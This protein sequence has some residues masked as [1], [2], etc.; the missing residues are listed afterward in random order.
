MVE[1]LPR[2]LPSNCSVN[3]NKGSWPILPIF[4]LMQDIGSIDEGEMFRAFNMGIGMTIVIDSHS[5]EQVFDA[6]SDFTTP[7]EI[8]SVC[9]G[10]CE[11]AIV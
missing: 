9:S 3:I 7:Y 11:V 1:N 6:L 5:K 4:S 8:G 10:R 2:I